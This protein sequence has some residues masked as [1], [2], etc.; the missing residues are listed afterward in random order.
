MFQCWW[1]SRKGL[2]T[3]ILCIRKF[4]VAIQSIKSMFFSGYTVL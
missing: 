1:Q 3:R 4:F 2:L